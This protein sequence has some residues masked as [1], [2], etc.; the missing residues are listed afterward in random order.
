MSKLQ[1][2]R[3][4]SKAKNDIKGIVLMDARIRFEHPTDENRLIESLKSMFNSIKIHHE[5]TKD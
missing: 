3:Q 2:T 4:M 1:V 5:I